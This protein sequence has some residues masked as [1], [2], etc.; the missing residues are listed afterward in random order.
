MKKNKISVIV[1]SLIF[2]IMIAVISI[3]NILKPSVV[4]SESENRYLEQFPQFSIETLLDGSFISDFETAV[5]DQ[6]IMRDN[7]VTIKNVAELSLL[8]KDFN[9][10]YYA[11]DGYLI[12]QLQSLK[13]NND[14]TETQYATNLNYIK[15]FV[16]RMEKNNVDVSTMLVPTA[17][18]I[19]R[20]KLP[21]YAPELDQKE[22]I[23]TAKNTIGSNV[24]DLTTKLYEHKDEYIY[25][26]TDHHWTSLG[27]YY[28]Y[29]EFCDKKGYKTNDLSWYKQ[30]VL[31]DEFYGTT[32]SKAN[33]SWIK[34]DTMT[35]FVSGDA[36]KFEVEYNLDGNK[37]NEIF[38]KSYLNKKDK[39]PVYLNGNQGITK[40]IGGTQNGKKLLIIKDSY[41]N[42]FSTIASNDFEE[43]YMIDLRY[44]KTSLDTFIEENEINDVLILYNLIGFTTDTNLYP[45]N[46]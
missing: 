31:S 19:L 24:I 30:T 34:P 39:Y 9:G 27:A 13:L 21:L 46:K 26:R 5:S 28:A 2:V 16:E 6:F 32:Y 10:V 36:K 43:L 37:T 1:T 40:I 41:A 15:S 33:L 18:Y 4:F 23:D 35:A 25:Y 45:L 42:T 8:K 3:F 17:S 44:F 22:L 38:V 29:K 7:W 12:D 14:K 20:D 11:K